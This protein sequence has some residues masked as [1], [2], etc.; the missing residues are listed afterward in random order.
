MSDR[1]ASALV[2]CAAK[3][4]HEDAIEDVG[5][6][7]RRAVR[8]VGRTNAR[9]PHAEDVRAALLR[10]L[11]LFNPDSG[12]DLLEMRKAALDAVEFLAEFKPRAVGSIVDGTAQRSDRI[13]LL[14]ECD[15]P[16]RLAERLQELRIPAVQIQRFEAGELQQSFEFIAG[17]FIFELLA[18]APRK[19]PRTSVCANAAQLRRLIAG[20]A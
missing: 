20:N 9:L 14:C 2:E 15:P 13:K 10:R 3:L 11:R 1:D 6:A 17:K 19:S 18:H 12:Q 5:E 8:I 16:D 4:M 7:L